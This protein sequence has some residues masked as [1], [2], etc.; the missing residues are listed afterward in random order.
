VIEK[1][2]RFIRRRSKRSPL[3][4]STENPINSK[5]GWREGYLYY[6]KTFR[7]NWEKRYYVLTADKRLEWYRCEQ[8]E[9]ADGWLSIAEAIIY[10]HVEKKGVV[11]PLLFNVRTDRDHL[12]R[13]INAELKAWWISG[14]KELNSKRIQTGLR[15]QST[16]ALLGKTLEER[17]QDKEYVESLE[18]KLQLKRRVIK[19]QKTT[20]LQLNEELR[21][22]NLRLEETTKKLKEAELKEAGHK[23]GPNKK[24]E[25][26]IWAASP[27]KCIGRKYNKV[28]ELEKRINT[29][30]DDE[31]LMQLDI[32][33]LDHLLSMQ[34]T[35]VSK[36]EK[37]V[38]TKLKSIED[39]RM[40][41][42][43]WSRPKENVI[44]PCG[45][46][47]LC[48]GCAKENLICCPLCRT[49]ITSITKVFM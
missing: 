21:D 35:A 38:V 11:K 44:I 3:S 23:D 36:V 29:I 8:E 16:S 46:L 28:Q 33:Q 47:A 31:S 1:M 27:R 20:I 10:S 37:A 14:L 17:A 42:L 6:R 7:N 43:C 45:H 34:K 22:T 41:V 32:H 24:L 2:E 40:C 5:G 19:N 49:S 15:V 26:T 39:A 30:L 4:D 12:F 13:A 18:N 25:E 48:G 9:V